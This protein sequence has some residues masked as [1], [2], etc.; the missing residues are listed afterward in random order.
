MV[1]MVIRSNISSCWEN[2][3][4]IN[5]ADRTVLVIVV[6]VLIAFLVTEAVLLLKY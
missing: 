3:R 6:V 4:D 5:R 1:V 2:C